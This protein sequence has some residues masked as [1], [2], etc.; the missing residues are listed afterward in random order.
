MVQ[1]QDATGDPVGSCE[2]QT[3]RPR[4][5]AGRSQSTGG[6]PRLPGPVNQLV[7]TRGRLG[8]KRPCACLTA[9]GGP[10]TARGTPHQVDVPAHTPYPRCLCVTQRDCLIA[11]GATAL[12]SERL[13]WKSDAYRMLVCRLCGRAT[14]HDGR[15][16]A[17]CCADQMEAGPVALT[18]PYSF[19]LLLQEMCAMGIDWQI[20]L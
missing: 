1:A 13:L 4:L 10:G 14:C 12:M 11:H 18:V 20:K 3:P 19:K 7:R 5:A 2:R 17:A 15:T 8:R 9:D 6:P 16:C